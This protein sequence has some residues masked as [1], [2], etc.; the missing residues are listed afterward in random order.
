M[1]YSV[2][3]YHASQR[4]NLENKMG[5]SICRIRKAAVTTTGYREKK[6]WGQVPHPLVSKR[7]QKKAI[8]KII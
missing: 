4:T 5:K 6:G 7:K 2:R 1:Y 8:L 3:I